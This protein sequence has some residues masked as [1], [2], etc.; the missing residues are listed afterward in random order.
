MILIYL[1]QFWLSKSLVKVILVLLSLSI[2]I[3]LT[4]LSS[5]SSF[6]RQHIHIFFLI[7]Q[8]TFIYLASNIDVDIVYCYLLYKVII[9]PLKKKQYSIT[10]FLSSKSPAQLLSAYP[11]TPKSLYF[12]PNQ[13]PTRSF[14]YL[15][16][17]VIVV[18]K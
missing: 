2:F 11:I 16:P 14:S 8:P 10:D 1:V 15:I 3:S 13:Q 9:A 4:T 12:P 6:R 7:F 18:F 5:R 17:S